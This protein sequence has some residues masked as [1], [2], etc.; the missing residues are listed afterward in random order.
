M[1]GP[2]AEQIFQS[3]AA[4][5][6]K[7][8]IIA[9]DDIL[10]YR[11]LVA[12]VCAAARRLVEMGVAEGERVV[13]AAAALP[14]FAMAYLAVHRIG[15]IC[16]PVDPTIASARLQDIV[17]RTRPAAVVA[18]RS[19]DGAQAVPALSMKTLGDA[20]GSPLSE[21]SAANDLESIADIIF[22]TGTTGRPKGVMLSHRAIAAAVDHINTVIGNGEDDVEVL[23]LPLS[24]S[25]G[26][27]RLRCSLVAGAT[28]VL[29]DG[30]SNP[31]SV[32]NAIARFRAT[33]VASVPTGIAILLKA[34]A[35]SL[36]R[37]AGQLRYIEIGSAPMTLDMKRRLMADLPRTRLLMHYGLT[38]ASRSAF[39]NFHEAA[40]HLDAIGKPAPGVQMRIVDE[41]DELCPSS[42]YGHIEVRGDHLM[43]GYWEDEEQT[44]LA[45]VDG[46]LRTGDIGMQ[47]ESGYFSLLARD[48]DMVNIGGKKVAP[49]EVEAVLE[50]HP[51]VARCAC[52]GFPDPQGISGQII[53][54]F[55]V[56]EDGVTPPKKTELASLVRSRLELYKLPR[57]FIWVDAIPATVSGKIQRGRLR[58]LHEKSGSGA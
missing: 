12:G 14:E 7:P 18:E 11:E 15:A 16:I 49:Q 23:P 9:G 8:A 27:G 10:T 3:A 5:P 34:Q 26:L 6:D 42:V 54:A 48:D 56:A 55:L 53:K 41:N 33:G 51:S 40:D 35:D 50:E 22:T 32:T 21:P 36:A 17:A 4:R 31:G 58:E 47:D 39:I 19:L 25:F 20:D 57:D 30:F 44:R 24:H 37:F 28:L 13:L 46:W 52:V 29:V 1:P 2:L 38:E 43:S 45:L